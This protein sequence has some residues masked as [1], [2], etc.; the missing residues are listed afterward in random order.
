MSAIKTTVAVNAP[1][2]RWNADIKQVLTKDFMK[3]G[4]ICM[5]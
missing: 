4:L 5:I 3:E 1:E 2:R